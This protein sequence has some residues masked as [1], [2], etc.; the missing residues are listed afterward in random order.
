MTFQ[1]VT[2]NCGRVSVDLTGLPFL[3][4]R[5]VF[6]HGKRRG[7]PVDGL[8]L[9]SIGEQP[10]LRQYDISDR[11][12]DRFSTIIVVTPL[13]AL[14]FNTSVAFGRQEYPG[15]NFGL[16]NNDNQVY[17]LGFDYVPT[18]RVSM[19]VTY[20]FEKYTALQASRTANPLPAN[21]LAF[22]NDPTQQFNDPR[23]DWTDDSPRHPR[24]TKVATGSGR[25]S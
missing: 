22:L 13:S 20:G 24:D 3:S 15:T 19:G 6:E 18:D 7:T 23:R 8:E 4:V 1:K 16:R 17:S 21:T 11:D 5:G 25:P 12:S 10:T 14:S 9:L 2:L